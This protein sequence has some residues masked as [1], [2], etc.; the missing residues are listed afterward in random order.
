MSEEPTSEEAG[1]AEPGE[2][3]APAQAALP[4]A[5]QNPVVSG[6]DHVA[7]VNPGQGE[8]SEIEAST[9]EVP[10]ETPA[11]VAEEA[12]IAPEPETTGAEP[13]DKP[14][15]PLSDGSG[16]AGLVPEQEHDDETAIMDRVD[17]LDSTPQSPE[18]GA[19]HETPISKVHSLGDLHGWAPG[20]ITYLIRHQL[21]KIEIDGYPM[22]TENGDLHVENL[23]AAFQSP[24]VKWP[25]PKSGL[26][27]HP[28]GEWYGVQNKG[29]GAIKARWIADPSVAFVQ[30]GDIF[31]RADHSE[32]AAEILRQLIVD[33]PGRVFVLVGNHEQFMLE[34]DFSNWAH[35]EVRSAYNNHV[36]PEKGA[37]AHF[38]FYNPAIDQDEMME[39]VFSRYKSSVWTLF[40]TQGAVLKELGWLENDLAQA[41][42]FKGMLDTGWSPYER[43]NTLSKNVKKG[44]S[45]PGAISALT[46][47]DI[48]FHHAEPAAHQANR[49][50][51]L[52]ELH[53]T[54]STQH[55]PALNE[56]KIQMY[57]YGGESLHD[58]EDQRLLWARGSSSGANSGNPAAQEHLDDLANNW[59]GLHRIVHGH[60]PTVG[61]SEFNTVTSGESRPVSYNADANHHQPIK[62]RANNVRVHNIDEGMSPVYFAHSKDDPYD[63]CR[64]PIGL[65][66]ELNAESLVEANNHTN[67]L[68]KIVEKAS[69][70]VDRRELWK[71]QVGQWKS[72][73]PAVFENLDDR[74]FLGDTQDGWHCLLVIEDSTQQ[75]ETSKQ[76][77]RNVGG[78]KVG[79]MVINRCLNKLV[80]VPKLET[81]PAFEHVKPIGSGLLQGKTLSLLSSNNISFIAA[82]IEDKSLKMHVVNGFEKTFKWELSY[83]PELE[84]KSKKVELS[85]PVDTHSTFSVFNAGVVSI[86]PPGRSKPA[87]KFFTTQQ[88]DAAT[89]LG[90]MAHYISA[91]R[92]DKTAAHDVKEEVYVSRPPPPPPPTRQQR[93]DA[94]KKNRSGGKSSRYRKA[95]DQKRNGGG[96]HGQVT[97]ANPPGKSLQS[98]KSGADTGKETP[99]GT[100]GMASQTSDARSRTPSTRN[101]NA[102]DSLQ[103]QSGTGRLSGRDTP[104]PRRGGTSNNNLGSASPTP[105]RPTSKI[106]DFD[107][108]HF[109]GEFEKE[110]LEKVSNHDPSKPFIFARLEYPVTHRYTQIHFKI[111]VM[112]KHNQVLISAAN[113][114]GGEVTG[115]Y[116]DLRKY[117]KI[118]GKMERIGGYTNPD[119]AHHEFLT[120]ISKL[121][122][123]LNDSVNELFENVKEEETT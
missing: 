66:M 44:E 122:N 119:S 105:L 99:S 16:E 95:A 3:Q 9:D 28:G 39:E 103:G 89:T 15:E 12:E 76:L 86:G 94:G 58:S 85:I 55:H 81:P 26:K 13:Q 111:V 46:M 50:G 72:N 56:F 49:D 78:R 90:V 123:T 53:K 104:A 82:K 59:P 29:H 41:W 102:S 117:Q 5:P 43:A 45:I 110:L 106:P 113:G 30:V 37:R 36:K 65:R 31:D 93:Q 42:N 27:S 92:N 62:G 20:L 100:S 98:Q 17:A 67:E 24:I 18:L 25:P 87:I 77:S 84:S 57:R 112:K 54:I 35:N 83:A 48:L 1:S 73:L 69:M 101:K 40:L 80:G 88:G 51:H 14:A 120:R 34:N 33:A 6:E 11:D 107:L 7:E 91:T 75:A 114:R 68:V 47:N 74:L 115:S 108:E 2:G 118:D 109:T 4:D 79:S 96:L 64:V 60:T 52:L 116:L 70:Q 19:L 63:P 97:G 61:L 32:L 10:T 38:R 121:I 23:N 71:W 21:A 8:P 22:Q